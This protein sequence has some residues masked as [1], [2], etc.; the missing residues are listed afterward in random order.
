M[1]RP[2]HPE[3]THVASMA[4]RCRTGAKYR[5]RRGFLNPVRGNRVRHSPGVAAGVACAQP[6]KESQMYEALKALKYL[7]NLR[8]ILLGW[9]G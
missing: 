7:K 5:E 8:A 2:A 1:Y 9:L 4:G 3:S 6:T